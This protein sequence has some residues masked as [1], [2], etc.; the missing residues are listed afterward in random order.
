[1]DETVLFL[2]PDVSEELGKMLYKA[3]CMPC[4]CLQFT[5]LLLLPSA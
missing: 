4:L 1:L 2:Q 3:T 5:P